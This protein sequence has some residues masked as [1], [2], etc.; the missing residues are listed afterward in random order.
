MEQANKI[1]FSSYSCTKAYFQYRNLQVIHLNIE[2]VRMLQKSLILT[3]R[4]TNHCY[5]LYSPRISILK[6]KTIKI[7]L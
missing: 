5:F 1:L 7:K 6:Y 3:R 4:L 2:N